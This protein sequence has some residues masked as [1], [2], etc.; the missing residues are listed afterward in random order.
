LTAGG[1]VE[2]LPAVRFLVDAAASE[3]LP[4]RT[5]YQRTVRMLELFERVGMRQR[6]LA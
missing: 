2:P 5:F 4:G 1:G 6:G 3:E